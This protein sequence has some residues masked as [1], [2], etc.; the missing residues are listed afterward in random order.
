LKRSWPSNSALVE[1]QVKKNWSPLSQ[2][3]YISL[4]DYRRFQLA[5]FPTWISPSRCHLQL[6]PTGIILAIYSFCSA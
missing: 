2:Q 3:E 5:F 6:L 4:Q 1:F